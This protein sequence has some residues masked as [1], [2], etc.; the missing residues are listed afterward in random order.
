[1]KGCVEFRSKF[2]SVIHKKKALPT[3]DY[4]SILWGMLKGRVYHKN[5]P[6]NLKD[7]KEK[8]INNT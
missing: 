3:S 8:I 2:P 4:T 5:N 7:L 1:M 6:H